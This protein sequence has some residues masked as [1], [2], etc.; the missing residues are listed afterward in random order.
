MKLKIY[1]IFDELAKAFQTPFFM[2][3]DNMAKRAFFDLVN[4]PQSQV[5]KHPSDYK[6]Y[7]IGTMD[8]ATALIEG[9]EIPNIIAHAT[10]AIANE[11]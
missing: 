9:T 5:N 1:S 7:N 11:N 3:N 2:Q 8:D 10:D 4:D 6:L